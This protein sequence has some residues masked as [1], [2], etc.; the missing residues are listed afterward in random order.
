MTIAD[1]AYRTRQITLKE[2]TNAV[3]R[4]LVTEAPAGDVAIGG[5]TA[6]R[7]ALVCLVLF[8]TSSNLRSDSMVRSSLR[9]GFTL[10][11]LLVVIAIIGILIALLLPA[12]QAAREAARRS[13]CTN[14][15]KQIGVALHNYES[16]F[17]VLPP[18][19]INSNRS[20]THVPVLPYLEQAASYK[21]FDFKS[22]FNASAS[23]MAARE[24]Q[25]PTFKCPSHPASPAFVLPGQC[26]NGCGVT[27]Y[28]QSLGNN[29]NM[30]A[31]DGPFAYDRGTR[32]AEILDG[33]SN[34]AM[35]SEI[36]LGPSNGSP[37][38]GVV[39]AGSP[40]DYKVATRVASGTWTGS[41]TGDQ[42]AV[43][44]CDSRANTAYLYRGKQFYR[45]IPVAT[46]YSHTLTP[47]S[48]HR[49][50]LN[51]TVA[52]GHLAARSYHPGGVQVVLADGSVRFASDTIE[53][54]VW[55]AVGSKAGGEV[56]K[57]W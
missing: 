42:I 34:T 10:V 32:F 23:N 14:H 50:C 31:N 3:G 47:N 45:G 54:A 27:N 49:D 37:T 39:E 12:V 33:L 2:R 40:D 13:Q 26:P 36:L 41:S 9:H 29:A 16:T 48:K 55:R 1:N 38:S 52:R 8:A 30:S 22:D 57:D 28:V 51:D 19:Y 17:K 5:P 43:P 53:E 20:S 46:Y 25:I 4:D 6:D 15:L 18:G 11:E 44:D 56:I 21:L 35:F 24:Q 7:K